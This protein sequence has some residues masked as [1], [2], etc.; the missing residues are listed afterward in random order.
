MLP[1]RIIRLRSTFCVRFWRFRRK[2]TL[3]TVLVVRFSRIGHSDSTKS[4]GC[5]VGRML[6]ARRVH[7]PPHA[8][9][10]DHV[11]GSRCRVDQRGQVAFG[12]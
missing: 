2:S 7:M 1:G 4:V 9:Q 3:F 8:G 5:H 10:H 6:A 11:R 12:L